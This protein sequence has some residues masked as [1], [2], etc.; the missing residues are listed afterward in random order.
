MQLRCNIDELRLFRYSLVS[1]R[2]LF[3]LKVGGWVDEWVGRLR[4]TSAKVIVEVEAELGNYSGTGGTLIQR[5]WHN[6]SSGTSLL[7][8]HGKN[9]TKHH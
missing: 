2:I 3:R 6:V 7:N 4:L 5:K 9:S 1:V 8:A